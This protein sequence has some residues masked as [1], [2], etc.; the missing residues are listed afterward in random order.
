MTKKIRVNCPKCNNKQ[1]IQVP[2]NSFE[3]NEK[4][5]ISIFVN[6]ACNHP[7]IV[8]VDSNF[9]VRGYQGADVILMS[10]MQEAEKAYSKLMA[11]EETP[12]NDDK[13]YSP[14]NIKRTNATELSESVINFFREAKQVSENVNTISD[15]KILANGTSLT[16][17]ELKN[18]Y[19]NRL[20]KIE[21]ALLKLE[22]ANIHGKISDVEYEKSS[23]K[24]L[25][26]KDKLEKYYKKL[27]QECNITI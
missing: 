9:S 17:E 16:L 20:N 6:P 27:I 18:Q 13:Q 22:L 25:K 10:E 21:K 4:G 5:V 7:F 23:L 14:E 24:F 11:E 2:L 12:V 8:F 26:I 19:L 15:K 1:I 3:N